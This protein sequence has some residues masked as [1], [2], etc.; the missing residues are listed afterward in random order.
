MKSTDDAKNE[1]AYVELTNEG[2]HF[3]RSGR[4]D[5][6][7]E[8]FRAALALDPGNAY[9]LCGLGD[10]AR[11]QGDFTGA[12][13]HYSACLRHHPDNEYA[14]FGVGDCHRGL[15]DFAKAIEIW[16]ACLP[17]AK[18]KPAVLASI[19]DAYRKLSDF[20]EAKKHYEEALALDPRLMHAIK[21]L[22]Y[23]YYDL[24]MFREGVAYWK[25]ALEHNGGLARDPE[26]LLEIGNCHRRVQEFA[27]ALPYFERVLGIDPDGFTPNFGV[28]D[29][30]RGLGDAR[31][32]RRHYEKILQREPDN[33]SILTRAGDMCVLMDDLAAGD[34]YFDRALKQG[35]DLY[36]RLGQARILQRKDRC[37]EALSLLEKAERRFP[38][39]PRLEAEKAICLK[40][41]Q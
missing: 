10:A 14:L 18:N 33:T 17:R 20:A 25:D 35:E 34:D 8:R 39:N 21:G 23:L 4:L 24:K 7:A 37:R 11:K 9:A 27:E 28:A 12:L 32:A 26:V 29:C 1:H 6:A 5:E 38:A 16:H 41:L 22:G 3:L 31:R 2:Y 19:A 15:K 40:K 13:E 36:A 30:S